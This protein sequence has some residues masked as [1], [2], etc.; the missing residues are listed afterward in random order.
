MPSKFHILKALILIAS[1]ELTKF[2]W[3]LFVLALDFFLEEQ[4]NNL[5]LK[6]SSACITKHCR[7]LQNYLVSKGARNDIYIINMHYGR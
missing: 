5:M 4:N 6:E 1:C 3:S 2:G 7:I